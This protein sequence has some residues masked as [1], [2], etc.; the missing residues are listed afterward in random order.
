MTSD[1]A[2]R[3]GKAKRR[4][5]SMHYVIS[6]GGLVSWV[7]EACVLEEDSFNMNIPDNV[8]RSSLTVR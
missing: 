4:G 5:G 7:I 8:I 3:A 1:P 2:L 6:R